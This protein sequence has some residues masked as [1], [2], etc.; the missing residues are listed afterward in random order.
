[1]IQFKVCNLSLPNVVFRFY[2]MM[3]GAIAFGFAGQFTLAALFAGIIA[4]LTILGV[5]IQ[6]GKSKA[7][8]KE[9]GKIITIVKHEK[10]GLQKM[11]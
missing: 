3:A 10:A 11:G 4:L 7:A 5:S 9:T 2:L 6:F 1:M 8:Q